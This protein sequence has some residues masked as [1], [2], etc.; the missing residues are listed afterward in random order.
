[1]HLK[2]YQLVWITDQIKF[3]SR[4]CFQSFALCHCSIGRA[5][6][7]HDYCGIELHAVNCTVRPKCKS[8]CSFLLVFILIYEHFGMCPLLPAERQSA[9]VSKITNDGLSQS[10][11]G[12]ALYNVAVPT[13]Q[14]WASNG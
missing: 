4:A 6:A 11:T 12:Y 14:Q 5:S 3:D 2:F 9:R 8:F 13:W 1:M 10:G 7:S